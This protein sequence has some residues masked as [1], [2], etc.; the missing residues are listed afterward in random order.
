[1][2]LPRFWSPL[3]RALAQALVIL[4]TIFSTH[5]SAQAQRLDGF[6]VVV[7]AGHP[8]GS[9]SAKR[10]LVAA[11]R[12]GA[13]AIAVIP[14]LWQPS[15]SSPALVRGSDM[16]DEELRA[17]I[18]M[19][20]ELGLKVVVKPH[21]WVPQSW[22][23]AIAPSSEPDW[24]DWF[25]AYRAAIERIA[26]IAAQEHAEALALGTELAKTTRRPEW[27]ELIAAVRRLYSG[28]LV[29]FA[30]NVE[31]AET[32]PFWDRLDAIG[33]TLYPKLGESADRIAR[34]KT[35]QE[36]AARLDSL[37][38]RIGKPVLVGEIG[39]RSAVG[40]TVKPWESA[41]E[42]DTSADPLLQAEVL[43]DWLE[44]LARPSIQGV[45][46]WR[47]F[48]DPEAGGPADTDFTV[49]GKPAEGVLLC[50]WRGNCRAQ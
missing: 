47:W 2:H 42:R 16:P 12:I 8:F 14:F 19:A 17:A 20:H 1:M 25:A 21:V 11:R 32:V 27:I 46:I 33:V 4:L 24:Q 26:R 48:T 40:A 37:A 22:A 43:A 5:G 35:M 34:L 49:Q 18:R 28:M 15:P 45:L 23:G 50:I 7:S 30:H 38:S 41:E 36:T 6:N 9:E 3:V 10:A 13:T 44:V 29:Y 31:S 39:L